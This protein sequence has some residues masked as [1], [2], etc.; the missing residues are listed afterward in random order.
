[1]DATLP[2]LCRRPLPRFHDEDHALLLELPEPRANSS[3]ASAVTIP[4]RFRLFWESAEMLFRANTA[5]TRLISAYFRMT[6]RSFMQA[7]LVPSIQ[8]VCNSVPVDADANNQ[9]SS[10]VISACQTIADMITQNAVRLT[11]SM[12]NLLALMYRYVDEKFPGHGVT[13]IRSVI[14]LRLLCP[15]IVNPVQHSLI[16]R[17]P[18]RAHF[19]SLTAIAKLL[20]QLANVTGACE[21]A[22]IRDEA[23]AETTLESH[24]PCSLLILSGTTDIKVPA[25]VETKAARNFLL[26]NRTAMMSF[27]E[28]LVEADG[29]AKLEPDK[30]CFNASMA[31]HIEP[32]LWVCS[33][34]RLVN[35]EASFRDCD[36]TIASLLPQCPFAMAYAVRHPGCIGDNVFDVITPGSINQA[37]A[38]IMGVGLSFVRHALLDT[39]PTIP[40]DALRF[41]VDVLSHDGKAAG[42]VAGSP[43]LAHARQALVV[44]RSYLIMMLAKPA[45]RMLHHPRVLSNGSSRNPSSGAVPTSDLLS[46]SAATVTDAPSAT[47]TAMGRPSPSPRALRE[48]GEAVGSTDGGETDASDS[49]GDSGSTSPRTTPVVAWLE[50]VAASLRA[51]PIVSTSVACLGSQTGLST[52]SWLRLMAQQA[53]LAQIELEQARLVKACGWV[54]PVVSPPVSRGPRSPS[55]GFNTGGNGSEGAVPSSQAVSDDEADAMEDDDVS[56]TESDFLSEG[57]RSPFTSRGPTRAPSRM[58]SSKAARGGA[59]VSE[60]QKFRVVL[61]G[62]AVRAWLAEVDQSS[63]PM[64]LAPPMAA[65]GVAQREMLRTTQRPGWGRLEQRYTM[66][67]RQGILQEFHD[68]CTCLPEQAIAETLAHTDVARLHIVLQYLAPDGRL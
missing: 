37:D 35:R 19:R 13:V 8:D 30:A 32:A 45:R 57:T 9:L 62:E 39:L 58:G 36:C 21:H 28:Y 4:L 24:A 64:A 65:W 61:H 11:G 22:C 16:D 34:C 33:A 67:I 23:Q 31:L 38:R 43:A 14:F 59:A 40:G 15:A 46:D 55:A 49:L 6:G 2:G 12:R 56:G 66:N 52:A 29:E 50:R 42:E 7:A 60:L 17:S 68:V 47:P 1:M 20:Q 10:T 3:L 48:V 53:A 5:A 51:D 25:S 41:L 27:V 26:Q 54:P 63:E 44:L 18:E